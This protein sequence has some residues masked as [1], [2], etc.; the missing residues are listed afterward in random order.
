MWAS[1]QVRGNDE[2]Q[3]IVR[4]LRGLSGPG[5]EEYVVNDFT[6]AKLEENEV[7][8]VKL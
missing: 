6:Y 4:P 1:F 2:D 7:D 8:L 3:D 5:E